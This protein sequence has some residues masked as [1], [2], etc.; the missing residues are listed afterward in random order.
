MSYTPPPL[1]RQH[2][3]RWHGT[4]WCWDETQSPV[5][6]QGSEGIKEKIKEE[7]SIKKKKKTRENIVFFL[8]K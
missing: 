2:E 8:K 4:S 5:R 3:L 6:L 1:V 7:N